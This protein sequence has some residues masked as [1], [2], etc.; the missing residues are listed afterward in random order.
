MHLS[1]GQGQCDSGCGSGAAAAVGGG[2]GVLDSVANLYLLLVY[3]SCGG[4][5]VW[6]C[7]IC[8]PNEPF[9][10]YMP[11]LRRLRASGVV[12]RPAFG[13]KKGQCSRL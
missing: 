5:V 1:I 9:T 11:L 7:M 3:N 12:G 2:C 13:S 8:A 10:L 6:R 4:G